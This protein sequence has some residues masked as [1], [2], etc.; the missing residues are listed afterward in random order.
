MADFPKSVDDRI[1]TSFRDDGDGNT[2]QGM[3]GF[4]SVFKIIKF[5]ADDQQP[6]YIGMNKNADATD[7]DTEWKVYKFTYSGSNSTQIQ[8]KYGSWTGRAALF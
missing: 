8:I 6:T 1:R 3:T 4:G 5:D 7:A 2:A